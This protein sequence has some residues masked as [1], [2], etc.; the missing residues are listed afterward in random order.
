[1]GGHELV[2][3]KGGGGM[4]TA[5]ALALGLIVGLCV[6][7]PS[8]SG[9]P[10]YTL[11]NRRVHRLKIST[12]RAKG[13]AGQVDLSDPDSYHAPVRQTLDP[14]QLITLSWSTPQESYQAGEDA[15][16]DAAPDAG[17]DSGADAGSDAGAV[18]DADAGAVIDADAGSVAA[19]DA[20]IDGD[21]GGNG[22]NDAGSDAGLAPYREP[23]SCGAVWIELPEHGYEAVLAWDR[24]PYS[25]SD[26]DTWKYAVVIEGTKTEVAVHLPE[27]IREL[28]A[29][30]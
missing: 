28:D 21:A 3:L 26:D 7:C 27:G 18:T 24:V 22:G 20:G 5:M 23:Q 11:E 4:R 15:G 10:T 8:D 6:A 14:G 29:P 1:M 9:P 30:E 25:H 19:P 16:A 13:C 2:S 17:S 12:R